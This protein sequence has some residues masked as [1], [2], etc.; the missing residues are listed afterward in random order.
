MDLNNLLAAQEIDPKPVLVMRHRPQE[1][2]LRKV[3]PWLAAERPDLF[4]AYQQTHYERQE[5]ALTRAK[6]LASFIG[7]EPGKALFVGLYKVAQSRPITRDEFWQIPAN[8]ELKK[9]GMTGWSSTDDRPSCLL[10]ELDVTDTYKD[11][12]GKLVLGW[13]GLERNW[14][15]WA[16]QNQ[17]PVKAI[18]EESILVRAMPSADELIL[19]WEELKVLPKSWGLILSQWRGVYLMFDV[20]DGRGYAGA[21]YGADNLYSRWLSY[22]ES[23]HGGNKQLRA[24]A[25]QNLRFSILQLVAQDMTAETVIRL[26]STW[27][28]RLHT[29]DFGLNDN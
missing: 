24:R 16:G 25:P 20:S 6:Y 11:W 1:R 13:T 9:L 14:C 12:K 10:F 27:K 23:G 28:E 18:L 26:E 19:T 8:L 4:N 21:A 15:R 22:A 17:F 2:E 29:R 3:L 7:H 5:R